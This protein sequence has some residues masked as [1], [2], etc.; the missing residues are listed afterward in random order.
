MDKI[1]NQDRDSIEYGDDIL[2]FFQ[3]C[4]HLK[5]WIKNDPALPN[6]VRDNIE[7]E[8]KNYNSLMICADL[9]NRSKHSE[10]TRKIRKDAK[11]TKMVI[12]AHVPALAICLNPYPKQLEP[13]EKGYF[14][15]PFYIETSDG[16][17]LDGLSIAIQA[18]DDW[19]KILS[20]FALK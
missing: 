2:G 9:T 20:K 7:R 3:N 19:E 11:I 1:K 5:D 14:E 8:V 16:S 18:V 12:I 13:Q 4:W 17:K 10:L 6:K 15:H